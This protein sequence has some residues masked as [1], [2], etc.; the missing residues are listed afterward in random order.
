ME[1]DIIVEN[2]N[3]T[4]LL[5]V[6]LKRIRKHKGLSQEAVA[7]KMGMRQ[8]TVSDIENGKGTL[9]SLMKLVQVLQVNLV[10]SNTSMTQRKNSNT[11]SQKVLSMLEDI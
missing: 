2:I 4:A 1:K 5:G 9:E 10:L 3:T 6:S 7:K 8:A 11:K